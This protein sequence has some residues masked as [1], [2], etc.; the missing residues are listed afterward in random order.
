MILA[1]SIASTH[2]RA[3]FDTEQNDDLL[4][5][6]LNLIEEKRK[7]A[8]LKIVVY[9]QRVDRYYNRKVKIQHFKKGDLMRRLLLPGA[10]NLQEEALGTNWECSYILDEDIGNGA[11]HFIS[12]SR[13]RVPQAW[14]A[15]HL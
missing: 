1:E 7:A 11:Y 6:S 13:A 10:R 14:N 12:V 5:A 3:T 15:E 2:K 4:A 9:Q 8:C